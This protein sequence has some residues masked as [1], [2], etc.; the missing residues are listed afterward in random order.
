MRLKPGLHAA[1]RSAA[2]AAGVSLNNYC[3]RKLAAPM[4]P[5]AALRGGAAIVE[6]AADLFGDD[7]EIRLA[8]AVEL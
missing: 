4:G 1:L 2:A 5:L 8:A 6:R 7:L 3:A